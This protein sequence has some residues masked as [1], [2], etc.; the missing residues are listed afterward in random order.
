M[1]AAQHGGAGVMADS[2]PGQ[3]EP[4]SGRDL[5][6]GDVLSNVLYMGVPSM[7][8]FAAMVVYGLTDMFWLARVGTEQ[9]A[10]VTLFGS[11]AM[12]LGSINS[13]VGSGSVAV[14]SRRYGERDVKGTCNAAEQTLVMKFA[15]GMV[16]GL[17]G[18]LVIGHI[19]ALMTHD[20]PL[21]SLGTSYGK[22]YFI[23][24][25]FMFTSYTVYTAL[26][27]VGDAPK[28]MGIMLF[29]TALNMVLDPI[30]ILVFDLG[31]QG[32][33]IATVVSAVS[34][35][36]VG[37]W[38]MASG[39]T[40]IR[41]RMRDYRPDTPVMAQILK[42]GFPPFLEAVARSVSMWLIAI[43]VA[44]YGATVVASYGISMRIMEL[45]IVFAVGLELGSSAIVG[46]NMGAGQPD[47]AAATSRKAALV[48]LGITLLLSAV[49]IAFARQI[50]GLFGK[51]AE[52]QA[53]GAVVLVYFAVA[54][55]FVS[56][57]IALSS[58]FYGS[59]NTWP[60][61][62]AGLLT[63]WIFQIPLT[64][65]LVYILGKPAWAIW[66]VMVLTYAI[67]M[68]LLVT[69]FRLGRWKHRRV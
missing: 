52:V 18:Y 63:T 69:W 42:I 36:V 5:T 7:I 66:T 30:L 27:G 2:E 13:M 44:F 33:A 62:V 17:A 68:S 23:G 45:G 65:V 58:A 59:G 64:A 37:V 14:I 3:D 38:V 22:I 47:R 41:I 39:A 60:P 40:S 4:R 19:L 53:T 9:V 21:V 10:G 51:S 67:Y 1:A 35:V 43:F 31:V 46:Q 25:P 61:T 48:A 50:M 54:Q 55:P 29:S 24:L 57:A 20:Q 26:R 34:A 56:T 32:A 16:M 6:T 12:V 8:G 28:A 15:M 49:E 11:V